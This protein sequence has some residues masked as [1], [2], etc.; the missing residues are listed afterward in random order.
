MKPSRINRRTWLRLVGYGLPCAALADAVLL[1]PRWLK[2]TTL[3][4]ATGTPRARFVHFTDLHH[5]G[6]RRFLESVIDRINRCR[7]EFVVFTG[8]LV[9]EAA[10]LEP[11][12]EAL[13]RLRAP[14][15]GVPG[16]HDYWAGIDFDHVSRA[17]AATGGAWLVDAA[18]TVAGGKVQLLGASCTRPF[19]LSPQPGLLHIALIHYPAWTTNL[20]PHVFDLVL[21]GHSH[22][23]Q[24]RLPWVGALVTPF[25]VDQYDLGRFR[26]PA[27]P[28][29]VGAGVGWFYLRLR[30]LCRPEVTVI[31][32]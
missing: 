6:D 16:N 25:G 22:G 28:L 4:L 19:G 15:Y 31:E 17:F 13:G 2:V 5:K 23:G 20:A 8:D 14:L 29:Y 10:H 12:L 3:R 1:E 11:A 21:A 32:I 26:T 30:F 7:P 9:E 18:A 24:V 27:G